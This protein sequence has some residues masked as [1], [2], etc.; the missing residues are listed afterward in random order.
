[1]WLYVYLP[2]CAVAL[3]Q[4]TT[5]Q[6]QI[7]TTDLD[8]SSSPDGRHVYCS[9]PKWPAARNHSPPPPH[10]GDGI[11]NC[12]LAGW[13]R[14]DTKIYYEMFLFFGYPKAKWWIWQEL[15]NRQRY[16]M[17]NIVTY[18]SRVPRLR[19]KALV[20]FFFFFSFCSSIPRDVLYPQASAARCFI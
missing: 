10:A 12:H 3:S 4:V 19:Q 18:K 9:F 1:M 11:K 20:L 8:P 16:T 2:L 15:G 7:D 13:E 6:C 5:S 14:L 17:G